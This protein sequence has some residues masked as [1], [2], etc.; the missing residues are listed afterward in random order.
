MPVRLG[1]GPPS[2]AHRRYSG[3]RS[4]LY[5][6]YVMERRL[7]KPICWWREFDLYSKALSSGHGEL[8]FDQRT[9]R[10]FGRRSRGVLYGQETKVEHVMQ[11]INI[12]MVHLMTLSPLA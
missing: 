8:K 12:I 10:A 11:I 3:H 6:L 2:A 5:S 1:C 4:T 9:L 7:T